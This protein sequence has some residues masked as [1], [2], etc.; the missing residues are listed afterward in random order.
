[1]FGSGAIGVMLGPSFKTPV[2][3][4]L[5]VRLNSAPQVAQPRHGGSFGYDRLG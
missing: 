1:V 2:T 3:I 5:L 4:V